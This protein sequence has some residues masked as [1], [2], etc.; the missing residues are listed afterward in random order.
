MKTVEEI[1]NL[2]IRFTCA[3]DAKSFG[4]QTKIYCVTVHVTVVYVGSYFF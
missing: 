2:I 3:A 1:E 4:N